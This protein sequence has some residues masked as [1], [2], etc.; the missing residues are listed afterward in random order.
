MKCAAR[1]AP[2]LL[3]PMIQWIKSIVMSTLWSNHKCPPCMHDSRTF[4]TALIA[5]LLPK[6]GICSKFNSPDGCSEAIQAYGVSASTFVAGVMVIV[7]YWSTWNWGNLTWSNKLWSW[8]L[9]SLIY[10]N[11]DPSSSTSYDI[12]GKGTGYLA[13]KERWIIGASCHSRH[14]YTGRNDMALPYRISCSYVP[15]WCRGDCLTGLLGP[16]PDFFV[17]FVGV[18]IYIVTW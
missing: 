13:F 8:Y 1:F 17:C 11:N 12:G 16:T 14:T 15:C 18:Y 7:M 3:K 9:S 2:I 5:L 10:P 4:T 6:W